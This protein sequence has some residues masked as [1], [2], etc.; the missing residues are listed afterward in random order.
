MIEDVIINFGFEKANVRGKIVRL[1]DITN[2]LISR[3]S[4][5]YAVDSVFLDTVVLSSIFSS[6]FK[7]DGTFKVQISSQNSIIK[8]ILCDNK[9]NGDMRAYITLNQKHI[10]ENHGGDVINKSFKELL[11]GGY[12][13]F[14]V[15]Q[16]I[17]E[18]YQ[19]ITEIVGESM[20]DSANEWF[21]L[22]E[23]IPTFVKIFSDP[24]TAKSAALFLQALPD[25]NMIEEDKEE[26]KNKFEELKM[27]ANTLTKNEILQDD[28]QTV[29]FRLFH[30][31]K[32]VV[33][34]QTPLQYK[35]S[36]SI[37]KIKEALATIPEDEL[38]KIREEQGGKINIDCEFCGEKYIV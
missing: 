17:G 5:G 13:V 20:E 10:Q 9:V 23:Q 18:P 34:A 21:K 30:E 31:F 7:Y 16:K 3:F 6:G 29:L 38:N 1:N 22:S 24:K 15:D 11:G 4:S 2:K 27:F 28:L 37:E 8:A 26:E 14:H 35:C 12:M 32:V 36:C 25:N 33:Y 19:A